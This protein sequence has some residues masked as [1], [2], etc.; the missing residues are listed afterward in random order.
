MSPP[1][2]VLLSLAVGQIGLM[3]ALRPEIDALAARPAVGGALRWIGARFMSVYLWHM[4]AL[5]VVTGITVLG[6]GYVT[7]EPGTLRWLAAAPLWLAAA[8][9]VLA[10]LLRVFSRFETRRMP[11]GVPAP[12]RRLVAAA[13]LGSTGLLGLAARGFTPP[14]GSGLLEGPIP[15]VALLLTGVLLTTRRTPA[16]IRG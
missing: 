9:V 8:G 16:P 7:P 1:T 14:P 11:I 13:L 2:A 3:L 4:P 6:L 10:G 5:V 15:W 12:T